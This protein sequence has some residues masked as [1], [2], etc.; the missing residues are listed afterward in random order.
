MERRDFDLPE[1]PG[2][3][4][5]VYWEAGD[6]EN[7]EVVFCVHGLT[8]NGRDFDALAEDLCTDR[9]VICP[10][11]A[12]RGESAPLADPSAYGVPTYVADLIALL[13]HLAIE[14]VDWI[15]TSMGGLIGMVIAGTP[16]M[17]RRIRRLVLN[18]VG[19]FVPKQ[20]LARIGE[21]VGQDWRFE[22]LKAAERH[23]RTVYMMFGPLTDAQWKRLT[24]V[25]VRED[26]D[27]SWVPNYDLAIGR[28][29]G[30]G[31]LEDADFWALW[32]QIA[33]PV[34][35][36]RGALSDVLPAD[37]ATR[38]TETGPRASLITL[39]GIGHAPALMAADQIA[40]IR[41]WLDETPK[42]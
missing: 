7:P 40:L 29:F 4:R 12:G 1:A 37:V 22:S 33:C 41:K 31:P 11:V 36:I 24:A 25:S 28:A 19:P 10:D 27:G 5:L 42:A 30:D 9:R 15:G 14:S 18:D 17:A 39:P 8:R 16:A 38:M 35:T 3:R 23:I 21:Y 13:D 6:P 34:L 20:A 26:R 2:G 32:E